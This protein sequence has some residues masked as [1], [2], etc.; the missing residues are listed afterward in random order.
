MA[1][2][3]FALMQDVPPPS[4]ASLAPT[5]LRVV[6]RAPIHHKSTLGAV[7]ISDFLE[8]DTKK[9]HLTVP[10]FHF[11]S[12]F[13]YAPLPMISV[14]RRSSLFRSEEHTSELQSLLRL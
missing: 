6:L 9:R 4:R 12:S 11:R 7:F 8:A 14:A 13:I 1:V 5:V 10:F 2:G 3:L